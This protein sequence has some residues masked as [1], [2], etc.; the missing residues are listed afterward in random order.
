MKK[1]WKRFFTL[2][3]AAE[4]FTLVE[5]IVVIAILAILAG[6]AVPAYSGYITKANKSN[7]QTMV[8]EVANALLLNYYTNP[9]SGSAYV[10]L[11][12][13]GVAPQASAN[14]VQ[15]MEDMYGSNWRST[16]TLSYDGW[17]DD[18]LLSLVLSENSTAGYVP[19]SS[20]MTGSTP[21]QLLNDASSL[22]SS[23]LKFLTKKLDNEQLF[24]SSMAGTLIDGGDTTAF[25]ALCSQYGI[26]VEGD[27]ENGYTFGEDV[28]TEQLTNLIV[29]AAANDIDN[30]SKDQDNYTA[31][32]AS[33]LVLQVATINA[34]VNSGLATD[35]D[36]AAYNTMLETMNDVDSMDEVIGAMS[37]F[38]AN[39][40]AVMSKYTTD[41]PI[42]ETDSLAFI[43]I[44]TAVDTVGSN[45][46]ASDLN[47][48]GLFSSTGKAASYFNTYVSAAAAMSELQ[49]LGTLP[50]GS[51]VVFLN[52]N[53]DGASV[54]CSSA[55][56]LPR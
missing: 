45:L 6:V 2:S 29:L 15:A 25:N 44:M 37:Y 35:A 19:G 24:Y 13:N 27:E 33:N 50:E 36:K 28:T 30:W 32:T 48:I 17:T 23:A 42:A 49:A 18:G 39:D 14:A 1:N 52:V 54:S 4:G 16:L 47:D 40:G 21:T 56:A 3:R 10:V 26:T 38:T 46:T 12:P 34:F 8:S 41:N 31:S 20:F 53:S 51:V 7:D 5:L 55:E 22:T 9:N 11:S 43:S